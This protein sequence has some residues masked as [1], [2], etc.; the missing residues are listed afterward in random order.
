MDG[1]WCVCAMGIDSGATMRVES[2]WYGYV[3]VDAQGVALSRA[4]ADYSEAVNFIR[5]NK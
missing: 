4:Y 3:V 2:Y 5:R 1:C